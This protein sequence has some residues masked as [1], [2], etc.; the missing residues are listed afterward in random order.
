MTNPIKIAYVISTSSISFVYEN[1]PY[2]ISKKNAKFE[3]IKTALKSGDHKLA[4]EL[5]D[6]L[7]RV[8]NYVNGNI[9]V[10]KGNLMYKG[11]SINTTLTKRII[12]MMNEGQDVNAMV[13]F[14]E[15]LMKNPSRSAVIELYD[16]L[17]KTSLPITPDGCFLAYKKVRHDYL[18]IYTGTIDNSV[19]KTVAVVRNAV[20]DDRRNH[21]SYGL[22]FC[23][24]SYLDHYS[25]NSSNDRVLLVKINP[26]DVVSIPTD[27]DFAKGRCCEYEVVA[28]VTDTYQEVESKGTVQTGYDAK[29]ISI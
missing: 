19:G 23:S 10:E 14:L 13:Q 15:N 28:D 5:A 12:D 18:D 4:L 25:S 6:V 20:D 1:K 3:E 9:T 8:T 7:S 21:C 24:I 16:F 29:A 2:L 22:H 17:E 11:S 26:A 27:Y